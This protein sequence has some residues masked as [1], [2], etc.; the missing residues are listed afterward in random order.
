MYFCRSNGFVYQYFNSEETNLKFTQDLEGSLGIKGTS[1]VT[2]GTCYDFF[3][4]REVDKF[5]VMS[6]CSYMHACVS[7]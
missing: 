5:V 7:R 6:I 4:F 2:N 3:G 1:E